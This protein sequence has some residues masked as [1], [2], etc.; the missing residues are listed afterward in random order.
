MLYILVI[1]Y[2]MKLL[3]NPGIWCCRTT[4]ML[5]ILLYK[6]ILF[7][8]SKDIQLNLIAH[9][10]YLWRDPDTHIKQT[11]ISRKPSNGAK[12]CKKKL[13]YVLFKTRVGVFYQI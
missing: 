3:E 4:Q 2:E 10:A 12:N 5:T 11:E 13:L 8:N 6:V 7:D 1:I 9:Y